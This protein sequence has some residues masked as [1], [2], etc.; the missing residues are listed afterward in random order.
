M[1]YPIDGIIDCIKSSG[2]INWESIS[3]SDKMAIIN[4]GHSHLLSG[5]NVTA[6]KIYQ[7]FPSDFEFSEDFQ[8]MTYAQV[9]NSDWIDFEKLGLVSKD[10][11]DKMKQLILANKK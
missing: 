1:Q 4:W 9:L 5:D 7:I 2:C 11:I 8:N 10:I 6:L 3:E